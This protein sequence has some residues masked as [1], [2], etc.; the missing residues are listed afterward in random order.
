MAVI[1]VLRLGGCLCGQGDG[2]V[3]THQLAEDALREAVAL[4]LFIEG[5]QGVCLGDFPSGSEARSADVHLLLSAGVD[6]KLA[7]RAVVLA[8]VEPGHLQAEILVLALQP[9]AILGQVGLLLGLEIH[10]VIEHLLKAA[11]FAGRLPVGA[12]RGEQEGQANEKADTK[13]P[14]VGI[15]QL[16]G[17]GAG[18]LSDVVALAKGKGMLHAEGM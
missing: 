15:I 11:Q 3:A 8:V 14:S 13:S 4:L 16:E 2:I 10:F 17:H 6:L 9:V 5:G 1:R 12:Q 7:V 18:N